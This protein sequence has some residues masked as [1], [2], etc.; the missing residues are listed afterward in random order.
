MYT[1]V[2]V[3]PGHAYLHSQNDICFSICKICMETHNYMFT[4]ICIHLFFVYS[5][6]SI[7]NID[8]QRFYLQSVV[9][10]SQEFFTRATAPTGI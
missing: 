6:Y 8:E 4:I 1:H 10:R 2:H 7:N 5:L 3:R 9:P